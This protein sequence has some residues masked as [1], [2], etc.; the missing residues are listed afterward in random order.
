MQQPI[1]YS[2]MCPAANHTR[3]TRPAWKSSACHCQIMDCVIPGSIDMSKVKFDAQA[4]YD[5][6]HNFSL[7]QEAF[8]KNH[9]TRVRHLFVSIKMS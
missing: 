7:L 6:K 8:T 1:I 9:I 3:R 5:C 4:E 2:G